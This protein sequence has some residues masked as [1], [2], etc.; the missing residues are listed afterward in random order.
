MFP[1]VNKYLIVGGVILAIVLSVWF[2]ISALNNTISEK[3]KRILELS[4]TLE[5]QK[6]IVINRDNVI[7]ILTY[8]ISDLNRTITIMNDRVLASAKE[9]QV[10]KA[11]Y[12]AWKAKPPKEKFIY[13]YKDVIKPNVDY[14]STSCEEG[15]ELNKRISEIDYESL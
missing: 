12:E 3:D 4:N 8:N 5:K 10:T 2:K 7:G 6:L 1:W 15:L 14:N 13:I 11:K 9:L